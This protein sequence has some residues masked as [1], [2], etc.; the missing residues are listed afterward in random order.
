MNA[1]YTWAIG[2]M[3]LGLPITFLDSW[4]VWDRLPQRMAV[5]FDANWNPNGWAMRNSAFD[6]SLL[7]VLFLLVVFTIVLFAVRRSPGPPASTAITSWVLL[8]IFCGVLAFVCG[9]HHWVLRYN[10][11]HAP[12][13]ANAVHAVAGRE[14]GELRAAS[15]ELNTR[16]SKLTARS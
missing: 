14:Q 4:L 8:V 15:F 10:L 3:W 13:P 12:P 7:I 11:E 5:H 9:L 6:F 2:L 1:R 16:N